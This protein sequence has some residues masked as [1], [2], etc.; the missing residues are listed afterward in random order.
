MWMG[1]REP[2]LPWFIHYPKGRQQHIVIQGSASERGT[3][4][5]GVPQGSVL[6]SLFH[7]GYSQ[8]VALASKELLSD[9][10]KK[11]IQDRKYRD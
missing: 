5:T 10:D 6:G 9:R 8:Q 2:V 3:I 1:I 4:K 11:K 7:V